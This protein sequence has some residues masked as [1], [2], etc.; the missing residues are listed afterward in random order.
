MR[1]VSIDFQAVIAERPAYSA[2][3]TASALSPSGVLIAMPVMKIG[4]GTEKIY[5]DPCDRTNAAV[6]HELGEP[7][8]AKIVDGEHARDDANLGAG[9]DLAEKG[10]LP[11]A[12]ETRV[13]HATST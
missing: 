3:T 4:S 7:S 5:L 9:A 11:D 6:D 8:A 2:S 13:A 12:R 1:A 10:R